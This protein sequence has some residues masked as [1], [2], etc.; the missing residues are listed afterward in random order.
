MEPVR[1]E[2]RVVK[3][4]LLFEIPSSLLSFVPETVWCPSP[5]RDHRTSPYPV[6]Q[7]IRMGVQDSQECGAK[8][9]FPP[10]AVVVSGKGKKSLVIVSASRN[11]HRWNFCEFSVREK[12][13]QVKVDLEGHTLPEKIKP[14]V[15][16]YIVPSREEEKELALLSRGYLYLYPQVLQ[17]KK[18]HFSWWHKPI[19]CGW[20]DQ[21]ALSMYLEGP[22]PEARALAYCNQGLYQRWLGR[23][24]KADIPVGTVT[25]DA[26]WSPAGTLEPFKNHWPDLRGFVERQHQQGRHVLL[27]FGLWFHEG[28]PDKWCLQAGK[29]LTVDSTHP[30]YIKY[31]RRQIRR[32]LSPEKNCFNADGFKIDMLQF[33]PTERH[34]RG[35]E[36]FGRTFSSGPHP[37]IRPFQSLWGLELLYRLQKEIYQTAKKIKPDA[38][39]TSSTVH[40]Y[41]HDTFDM[42]RLHDTGVITS[43]VFAAMK[44]RADLARAV[45]PYH[46]IDADDWVHSD[47]HQWLN[48]TKSSWQLGTPC[49][50]YAERFV[51]SWEKEPLTREIPLKDLASISSCWKKFLQKGEKN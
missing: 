7:S 41:F 29:K 8:F 10:L 37:R 31:L 27:W 4:T 1:V 34:S 23:L 44:A 2:S 45:L 12:G 22:G 24:Q 40:P 51:A 47:Y 42:V 33:T 26:G 18:T 35:G 38:L 50:F 43:D 5:S 19:Y 16:V 13:V 17:K 21:V 30:G 39:I 11:W 14:F 32:L 6:P 36:Q 49:L 15:S 3:E 9:T 25:I 20:G 28:L 48:Y 46:L